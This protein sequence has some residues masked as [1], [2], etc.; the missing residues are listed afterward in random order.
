MG[1]VQ[2]VRA[3]LR[4][5]GQPAATDRELDEEIDYHLERETAKNIELGMTPA[6]ARR[7]AL[8]Q[9]GGVQR[10][11]EGHRDIRRVRW[12]EDFLSD[13]RFAF[14]SLRRTPGIAGAVVITLALGIAANVAIFSAVNAVILRPLPFPGADR[15]VVVGE[16][17]R[18]TGV[19]QDVPR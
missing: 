9:F 1:L 12:L 15:F 8:V 3:R 11:R 14:R 4:A 6:E 18:E 16:D 2:G 17:N 5:L 13:T 7:M 10:A 19:R